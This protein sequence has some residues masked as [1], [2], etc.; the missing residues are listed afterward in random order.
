[1]FLALDESYREAAE[2]RF[3]DHKVVFINAKATS[4]EEALALVSEAEVLAYRWPF[5]FQV[6]LAFLKAF[7]NLRFVHKSGTGHETVDVDAMNELGILFSTNTG[8]NADSVAEQAV[9]LTLLCLRSNTLWHL[10][11]SGSGV[12]KQDPPEGT[13]P[14]E[15][16]GGKTVGIVGMGQIGSYTARMFSGFGVRI[17][18]HQRR[19]TAEL[20][21]LGGVEWLS[22][23]EL[24][25]QSDVVVLALPL[26]RETKGIIGARELGLMKQT[27]VLVNVGRGATID[28][29]ALY[30]ALVSGRIR[31]AGLDVFA[32][33]PT[34]PDHPLLKLENVFATPHIAGRARQI[35]PRQIAGS[36]SVVEAYLAGRRP[37]RLVN[38]E[39]LEQGRARAA[40]LNLH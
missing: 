31:A 10:N 2:G 14:H 18:G 22:L 25:S 24:L 16:L 39:I 30:D 32:E 8:I 5:P 1:M 12:W 35:P 27:A 9:L 4:R 40:H 37:P 15:M 29:P 23:D 17:V 33:E 38:P 13:F 21:I 7:P 6:D 19:Q 20:A 34:P 28:E 36:L 3:P 26:T 11:T